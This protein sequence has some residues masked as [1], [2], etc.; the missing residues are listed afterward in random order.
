LENL[1]NSWG[2][3]PPNAQIVISDGLN[4]KAIMDEGHL[5]PHLTELRKLLT[6]AGA[7]VS[8]DNIV[9]TRG[10]VR[11]G[12]EIGEILFEKSDP[13]KFKAFSTSSVNG[14]TPRITP[15]RSISPFS[16]ARH[17]RKRKLIM[18]LRSWCAIS[19]RRPSHPRKRQR[20]PSPS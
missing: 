20:K 14:P 15:T 2:A 16:R 18:M 10:R 17:G 3:N 11:A 12:Y 9:I 6:E 5:A 8:E 7:R 19:P 13:N 4:A 1:R